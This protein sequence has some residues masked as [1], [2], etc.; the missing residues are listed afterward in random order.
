VSLRETPQQAAEKGLKIAAGVKKNEIV[1]VEVRQQEEPWILGRVVGELGSY[2]LKA[3]IDT[4]YAVLVSGDVAVEIQKLE[5]VNPGT[6]MFDVTNKVFPVRGKDI[7]LGNIEVK[8]IQV[9]RSRRARGAPQRL[10]MRN[11]PSCSFQN[12]TTS[13]CEITTET[14]S[15]ILRSLL[16]SE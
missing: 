1:C 16:L 15:L 11:T 3:S 5:P 12:Q 6:K 4:P 13:R 7:R 2:E 9:R 8:Y 10:G 14:H